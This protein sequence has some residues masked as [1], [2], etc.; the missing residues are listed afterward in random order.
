[1]IA[2]A[3]TFDTVAR[4][5]SSRLG[6]PY[7]TP[8]A[9]RLTTGQWNLLRAEISSALKWAWES[10]WF[11]DIMHTCR[12]QLRADWSATTSYTAGEQVFYAPADA[13]YIALTDSTAETPATFD[14]PNWDTNNAFWARVDEPETVSLG[15]WQSAIA[16]TVGQRV[17]WNST[18]YQCHTAHTSSGSLLPSNTNYWGEVPD[19]EAYITYAGLDAAGESRPVIGRMRAVSACDPRS[20]SSPG[21]FEF[22]PSPLGIRIY[23]LTV[24]RPWIQYRVRCPQLTGNTWASGSYTPELSQQAVWGYI[25]ALDTG[26]GTTSASREIYSGSGQPNVTPTTSTALWVDTDTG[27]IYPYYE[28]AWR[29]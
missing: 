9:T 18:L 1:M 17:T 26:T 27:I 7:D 22:E 15:S 16:Y 28:G 19:F 8:S 21:E 29:L 20:N 11:E 5:V 24:T 10:Y 4:L 12:V 3:A 23:N 2:N 13:Y 6:W 14:D 25:S